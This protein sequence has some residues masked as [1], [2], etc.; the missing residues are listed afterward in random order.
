M[1]EEEINRLK[2][3]Q[4]SQYN[5]EIRTMAFLQTEIED[6]LTR[7]DLTPEDKMGLF[8]N[9]QQRFSS[10]HRKT[11]EP[12]AVAKPDLSSPAAPA[13][14]A[15]PAAAQPAD[16]QPV[17]A[18][19]PGSSQAVDVTQLTPSAKRAIDRLLVSV[20]QAHKKKAMSLLSL[21]SE[22][23]LISAD[24]KGQVIISGKRY[25]GSNFVD[26]IHGLYSKSKKP[27][28][29]LTEFGSALYE[30]NIPRSLVVNQHLLQSSP[31]SSL[32]IKSSLTPTS[33]SKPAQVRA[34]EH[35]PPGGDPS[36]LKVYP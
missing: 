11:T 31:S 6:I 33:S 13:V 29:A 19:D 16:D 25:D 1:S 4:I 5:P 10:L 12:E 14:A 18:A 21:L 9:A 30:L 17:A 20:P 28:P 24:S 7:N 35:K 27:T 3:K 23:S 26:L 15:Q 32:S 8:H 2:S 36:V 34:I 22:N